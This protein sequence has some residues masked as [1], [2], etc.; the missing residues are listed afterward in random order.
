[1]NPYFDRKTRSK[2]IRKINVLRFYYF[3]KSIFK[4]PWRMIPILFLVL[5]FV[6]L[7]N[8]SQAFLS[9]LDNEFL[10]TL[11][12]YG[13]SVSTILLFF[14]LL[15]VLLLLISYPPRAKRYESALMQIDLAPTNGV[16]PALIA[17][18]RI[19]NTKVTRLVFYS[20]GVSLKEWVTR[21]EEIEDSFNVHYVEAPQYGGRK[22][23]NR[24]LIVL[25]VAPGVSSSCKEVLYD[26][27]L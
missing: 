4:K 23:N 7:W 1:M 17:Q 24:N 11:F 12:L 26:D 18:M 3:S 20:L 8:C 16:P 21:Q 15:I 13:L 14:S 25:T 6:W 10:H 27:E 9:Q 22:G 5:F 2:R 19:K